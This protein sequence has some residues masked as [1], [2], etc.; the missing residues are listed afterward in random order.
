MERIDEDDSTGSIEITPEMVRAGAAALA[1]FTNYFDSFPEGAL[2]IFVAMI[3]KSREVRI[4]ELGF[5]VLD[6]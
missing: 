2:A 3:S 6:V 1:R 5:D 4:M